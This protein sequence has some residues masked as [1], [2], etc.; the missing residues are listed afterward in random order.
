[1]EGFEGQQRRIDALRDNSITKQRLQ[2]NEDYSSGA[3]VLPKQRLQT[4]EDYS[5]GATVLPFHKLPFITTFSNSIALT[6]IFECNVHSPNHFQI[7]TQM[8]LFTRER[9]ASRL[10]RGGVAKH[11]ATTDIFCWYVHCQKEAIGSLWSRRRLWSLRP[12]EMKFLTIRT[13]GLVL[14]IPSRRSV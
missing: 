13:R 4:N 8:L 2:T 11:G 3:T 14:R 9:E 12:H 10:T 7:C 5:F 1:M 6:S